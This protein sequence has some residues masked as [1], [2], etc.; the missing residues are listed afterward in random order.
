MI[1]LNYSTHY[2]VTDIAK[3]SP[4]VTAPGSNEKNP[5]PKH[6]RP[7]LSDSPYESNE[8]KL[9][10]WKESFG[11]M[12]IGLFRLDMDRVRAGP[13]AASIY[14]GQAKQQGLQYPNEELSETASFYYSTLGLPRTFAQWFQITALHYWILTVRMRAMPYKYGHN[15][16]QKFVDRFFKDMELR[17]AEEMNISSG[18]IIGNY[19]KDFYHQT[20]GLVLAY[21][22]GFAT[23]DATLAT[24]LW[25]NLFNGREDV[26]I[27][28][29]EAMVSYVRM[30]L[31][32]LSKMS[33]REFGFGKFTFVAPNEIV[34]PLSQAEEAKLKE[35]ARSQFEP[36][37]GK[38]LPSMRSS[39]SLDE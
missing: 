11:E 30:Q 6:K 37:S 21:D 38:V 13:V 36:V 2:Y 34:K 1:Y 19:M 22:E 18:R 4:I 12:F 15:Y 24:A 5:I 32:V 26:D 10:G 31:Y 35:F 29:L 33:D 20:R 7:L 25:R 8:T 27:V 3:H 9:S 17:L 39:L 14:Y 23:N 16:Q 28:H